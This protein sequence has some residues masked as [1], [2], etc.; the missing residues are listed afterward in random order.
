MA[1]IKSQLKRIKTNQKATDRN[2]AYKS[3]LKLSL[4]HI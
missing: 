4:I 1:N 2:K 3:E